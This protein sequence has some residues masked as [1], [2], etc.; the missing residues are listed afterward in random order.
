MD[1]AAGTSTFNSGMYRGRAASIASCSRS[2]HHWA[3]RMSASNQYRRWMPVVS[4]RSRR[5]TMFVAHSNSNSTVMPRAVAMDFQP[6]SQPPE[7]LI[8]S[9]S[10]VP[11]PPVG[12]V[13]S[14]G[15]A[16]VYL[17]RFGCWS[18]AALTDL[19]SWALSTSAWV[20]QYLA[21]QPCSVPL[22]SVQ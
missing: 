16:I 1:R 21:C 5:V 7:S 20:V 19:W 3:A 2:S 22:G 6:S 18:R 9:R 12:P 15:M 14:A 13:G 4:R 17:V 11:R 8:F 10:D